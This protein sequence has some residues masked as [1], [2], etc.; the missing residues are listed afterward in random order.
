[1][2]SRID[3][4]ARSYLRRGAE[5]GFGLLCVRWRARRRLRRRSACGHLRDTPRGRSR[6]ECP[7]G[8]LPPTKRSNSFTSTAS[9]PAAA[10]TTRLDLACGDAVLDLERGIVARLAGKRGIAANRRQRSARLRTA[11]GR[12]PPTSTSPSSSRASTTS[13]W[14]DGPNVPTR[15]PLTSTE[16]CATRMQVT[17]A[18]S[19]RVAGT[20]C[21]TASPEIPPSERRCV[22]LRCPRHRAA[23]ALAEPAPGAPREHRHRRAGARSGARRPCRNLVACEED[24]ADGE[25]AH[26]TLDRG[27]ARCGP[28]RAGRPRS[29]VVAGL[30]GARQRVRRALTVGAGAFEGLGKHARRREAERDG[31]RETEC[32]A[33]PPT[34][35]AR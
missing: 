35:A 2:A 20:I 10:R 19:A 9:G 1:M 3:H 12:S 7:S 18:P 29:T 26:V 32:R 8:R 24:G 23:F 25:L 31:L 33:R 4:R 6:L 14:E 15:S 27:D 22:A 5:A 13:G 17:P 34:R 28:R 16:R 30:R 11:R 21:V